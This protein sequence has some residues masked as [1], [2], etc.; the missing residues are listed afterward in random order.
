MS[1]S[2]DFA[3]SDPSI[4]DEDSD[5]D[6]PLV[7][8][9][10]KSASS[11]AKKDVKSKSG[12]AK[13][14]VAAK[15][16]GGKK[17][18]DI[19]QRKSQMEH[20][21]L[22]PDTYIGSVESAA[23]PMWVVDEDKKFVF[24]TVN[25]VPGLFKIFDEILVNA[26]DNKIRDGS[27]DTIKVTIDK[28][29]GMISVMNNGRGI[30]V[31]IHEKEQIYV[32]ELIF[33]H[34][35]TSS[36]YDDDEKKV[37]G[38]R[39]GYGAKLCNIF[40]TEFKVETSD[41]STGKLFK[42]TFSA[43]M[44]KRTAPKILK[45][46]KK[47]YTKISF[48]PDWAKFGMEK[49]D[50]DLLA[51]LRKRVYDM[52]GVVKDVK[53]YLND[54]R[55][56]IKNF[57]EYVKLY[58][59]SLFGEDGA[60]PTIV[61]ECPDERWE[62]CFAPSDGQFQQVSF[63]NSICTFKGG[64][65]VNAVADQIVQKLNEMI[66]KKNKGNPL[67]PH[68][69][70]SH[71][72]LFI[73]CLIENPSFDSQTKENMTLKAGKFGSKCNLSDDFMKKVA[74][75]GVL[76]NI[77]AL[78]MTKQANQ[79][80]QTDGKKRA[81]LSGIAKLDD[82]NNAGTKNAKKCTLIL[83]E[84]DSAKA[85][86]ISGLSVVGRDNYGVFP[87]RGKLLNVREAT[88]KQIM[89]NAEINSIKQIL[90]LKAD[91][92]YTSTDTL[93]YG[94]VMIMADQDHDGSH[95]K[96]L[97][98][99]LFDH[100][101]PSLLKT[102]NFL[103]Q[104]ITPIIR[105][106][107][108]TRQINF[109]NL[110]EYMTWRE[111]NDDR[112]WTIKYYK[113]LGTS[114]AADAKKYFSNMAAHMKPF[115][116]ARD[117]DRQL[118][119]LA[120]SKKRAD[121]RKEWLANLAAGTFIDHTVKEIPINDFVN[122]E[123]ILFSMADNVRSIP[124]LVDGCKPGQRKII[125]SCFKRNLTKGELKVAQLAGYVSEHSAYHHGE[126]S[127]QSTIIGLAQDFVGSNNVNLLDPRG[128]FGTRLQGGKDHAHARY[129]FTRL[130]SVT[131]LLF[132]PSDDKLLS[133]LNEENMS[134]EPEWYIPV[135]P[136]V[137]V[138]GAEG[139]GTGWSTS[140]PNYNPRA[141]VGNLRRKL[142]GLDFQPLDPWYRGFKG[143]IE[144]TGDRYKISGIFRKVDNNTVEITELP[145]GSWTQTYKEFLE[146]QL[147]GTEK[148][149]PSIKDY[150][151][152]HTDT[153][154]HFVVELS[155]E[156]MAK[157]E[158]EGLEKKFRMVSYKLI[159]NMVLFDKDGRLRKYNSPEEI[160]LE[161]YDLRL[162]FYD[163]RKTWLAATLTRELLKLSNQVRFIL[164]VIEG[165]LKVQNRKRSDIIQDLVD[166]N[167]DPSH[168][169][170]DKDLTPSDAEMDVSEEA[171]QEEETEK[172]DKL[173]YN[174]LLSMP[175]WNLTMEKVQKMTNDRDQKQQELEILLATD[176]KD[177]WRADLCAFLEEWDVRSL[178]CIL[179]PFTFSHNGS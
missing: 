164:E 28:E 45:A 99:N 171:V 100:F 6:V 67:K 65:H 76:E 167:Y 55:I 10:K 152:Y 57:K 112:G 163:K 86:A 107:K 75:S 48:I 69:V 118:I 22:R 113:G 85:L 173:D 121:D 24:R 70:K 87:L 134:I 66:K 97:I 138:N 78:A 146:V 61:Y 160:M 39:N 170:S 68:Q 102:P 140:L 119:E 145:V 64:T 127:L 135:I 166:R 77:M 26:A 90:G 4:A 142:D 168:K 74:R 11:S 117:D 35:L 58:L 33:G 25:F 15:T 116:R 8:T 176:A 101:W 172:S 30:P 29:N 38:G 36:N 2:D 13:K 130:S 141:I 42:Q 91:K 17:I 111:T 144:R 165:T 20:I 3:F 9:P 54:E 98:I 162:D 139:I 63:V 56:Q 124:S 32:P 157:A 179:N 175:I 73:N 148:V 96:G 71:M 122:R 47:D 136:T 161:F 12:S 155:D 81:R 59:E 44:S 51:V 52:A 5:F 150:K 125:F 37:T 177:L 109:Y 106:T 92:E 31:Q 95:I 94:H 137:L 110:P 83:T 169:L 88:H 72:F 131:R 41:Q 93:R 79:L 49:M 114:T 34:L 18:E 1:D 159:S 53:V 126:A 143:T 128:Q 120:F 89:E 147:V 21:L 115:A 62:I 27:M 23:V 80:K 123:L 178:A 156:Q 133:Y 60:K 16:A 19:Y 82:A 154:V 7:P 50:D 84:G 104:F 46:A 43:N 105:V 151:E 158:A 103:L 174:Y 40:S 153:S 129:I 132:H 108:G 14:P 149:Q